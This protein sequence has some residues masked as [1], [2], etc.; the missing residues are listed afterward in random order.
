MNNVVKDGFPDLLR[1]AI[2]H[3]THP[4]R[5]NTIRRCG[6]IVPNPDLPES[7]RWKTNC[8]PDY[9]SFVRH[10]GGISLFDFYGFDPVAYNAACPMSSWR[11]FV[12]VHRD[13][14]SA[15]WLKIDTSQVNGQYFS[16]KELSERQQAEGAFRHTLMPRIEAGVVGT[17]PLAAVTAAYIINNGST[18]FEAIEIQG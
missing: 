6:E 16:P 9:Y 14:F 17:I 4:D 7:E 12:P 8:G 13:W 2:W 18:H 5:F 10:I 1:D 3:T 15:I 11:T